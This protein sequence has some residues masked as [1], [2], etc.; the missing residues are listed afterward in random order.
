[1][2]EKK[3]LLVYF[4]NKT[5]TIKKQI[6]G[7]VG[8][9]V[10]FEN[11]FNY[12]FYLKNKEKQFLFSPLLQKS[13]AV[14]AKNIH[15]APLWYK[16]TTKENN[17]IPLGP[18]MNKGDVFV[19]ERFGFCRY[20]GVETSVDNSEKIC[21]AFEDGKIKIDVSKISSVFFFSDKNRNKKREK[22]GVHIQK[23]PFYLEDW[24]MG[25][26]WCV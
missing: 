19:H 15:V 14:V 20:V 2:V 13:G 1:M 10:V 4:K 22:Q 12:S 23:R 25:V 5:L 26:D 17:K 16:K 8:L 6:K 3:D 21:L 7:G 11:Y 9:V 18:N 24:V